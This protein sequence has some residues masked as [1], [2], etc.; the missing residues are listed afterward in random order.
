MLKQI[1]YFLIQLETY[2]HPVIFPQGGWEIP[3]IENEQL[4]SG[5]KD[6]E[7]ILK[8]VQ[9]SCFDKMDKHDKIVVRKYWF[10]YLNFFH[11]YNYTT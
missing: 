4:V 3:E 11:A 9:K 2:L 8:I 7:R 1:L 10:D 5:S 6:W